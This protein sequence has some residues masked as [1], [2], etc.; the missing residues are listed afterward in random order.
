MENLK[1]IQSIVNGVIDNPSQLIPILEELIQI[2][3]DIYHEYAEAKAEY[4][5]QKSRKDHVIATAVMKTEG[6]SMSARNSIAQA[7]AEARE[8]LSDLSG[9][10]K[11]YLIAQAELN[12]LE[13]IL[14]CLQ[15]MNKFIVTDYKA[16]QFS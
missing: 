12:A 4:E 10:N 14:S 6:S 13:T 9:Y 5:N 15:S 1:K 2:A 3:P 8:Y 7:S 11:R 16:A